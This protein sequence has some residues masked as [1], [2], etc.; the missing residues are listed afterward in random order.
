MPVRKA[1]TKRKTTVK[2]KTTGG[3]A[4]YVRKIQ[5]SPGVKA[6]DRTVKDLERRLKAAKKLK[7]TKVKAARK[8]LKC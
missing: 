2:R 5:N 6:A 7:A 4:S 8:K 1:A 3:I